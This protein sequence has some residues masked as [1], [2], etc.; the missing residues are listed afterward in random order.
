[1]NH[2]DQTE[3]TLHEHI[4]YS[5][6]EQKTRKSNHIQVDFGYKTAFAHNEF[7]LL[8]M[9]PSFHFVVPGESKKVYV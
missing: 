8:L 1:M 6:A 4:P 2:T 3:H 7:Q 5:Y 9:E